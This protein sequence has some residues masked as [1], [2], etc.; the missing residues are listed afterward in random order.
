MPL[1]GY[2][3]GKRTA[4]DL[5]SVAASV[6]RESWRHQRAA[7]I[8]LIP[9]ND[10]SLYDQMLDMMLVLGA[11]PPRFGWDGGAITH[12]LRFA[13]ARG[14]PDNDEISALEMTQVV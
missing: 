4:V 1:E 3:S 8:D 6:R 5:D 12:D 10:F 13:M 9:V 14:V 11:I 2:W 7:G